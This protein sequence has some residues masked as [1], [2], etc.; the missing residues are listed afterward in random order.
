MSH[1]FIAYTRSDHS[2]VDRLIDFFQNQGIDTWTDAEVRHGA[3]WASVI[4]ESIDSASALVVVMTPDSNSSTWVENELARARQINLPIFPILL[5]GAPFFSLIELQF[6]DATDR[7]LPDASFISALRETQGR[8]DAGPSREEILNAQVPEAFAFIS[9]RRTDAE[10]MK[11]PVYDRLRRRYGFDAI[12]IDVDNVP[13]SVN[14]RETVVDAVS[15]SSVLL[16]MIA[17]VHKWIGQRDTR[18]WLHHPRDAVLLELQTALEQAV[19]IVPLL[20]SGVEPPEPEQLPPVLE[21]FPDIVGVR[22]SYD[23][24]DRD[25]EALYDYLDGFL[26]PIS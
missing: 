24:L 25:I 9:Y 10:W 26:K 19:P 22:L 20:G 3:N 15:R 23:T 16:A 7:R 5:D 6:F 11:G 18:Q 17:D 8:S 14:W 21:D 4:R 13:V 1:V 2:Y 12:F